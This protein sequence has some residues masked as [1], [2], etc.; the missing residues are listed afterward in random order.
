MC[1]IAGGWLFVKYTSTND[2]IEV[3][4]VKAPS[5]ALGEITLPDRKVAKAAFVIEPV[6]V[7]RIEH[8]HIVS[9]RLAYDEAHHIEVKAPVSGVL[10]D[11]LVK[12]GDNVDG[13]Q[14][15]AIINSPEIGQA[16]ATV[17]NE[18][19]KRLSIQKQ[20][21]R[22]QE[23]TLN[24]TSL[25]GFLDNNVALDEIETQFNDKS[26][27]DY[28]GEIMSAYSERFLAGQLAVAARPLAESGSLPARTLREREND[29]HV[30]NAKFRSVRERTAYDVTVRKQQLEASKADADRQV[31]IA[32]N[33][34]QTLLGSA[35]TSLE[36][37]TSASLSKLEVRAPFAGT[38]ESRSL[39]KLERVSQSDSLFVLANT[40]S[41][42]VSADL[43][44][45]DWAVMSIQ[46]G[47]AISVEAPAIP[48]RTFSAVVH[49]VGREVAIESNSLPLIAT[50][51]NS[52]G[53]LR[54]G[55]FVRVSMS[56]ESPVEVIAVK[57]VSVLQ[58]ENEL[59]VFVEVDDHTFRRVGVT[60]GAGNE[61]WLEVKEG[62]DVGQPVIAEGAFLLKSELLLAGEE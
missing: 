21:D 62:L 60:V 23:V 46:P 5:A 26:L 11:V 39:A 37:V 31:M 55:M 18:E 8:N 27:G 40:K 35:D 7:R 1:V 34:L 12:P 41:L 36:N 59:F 33:H 29:R 6:S 13:G 32:L 24:L 20:M 61:D 3:E 50:I 9:G 25:F 58:H 45:N 57:P 47:Q 42:Y 17:L 22:L 43:R 38:I 54:P 44:E 16:R 4:T 49:Y 52:D 28:R 15:L 51:D 14:V 56:V 48:G 30:T 2:T 10:L 19:A 53:V